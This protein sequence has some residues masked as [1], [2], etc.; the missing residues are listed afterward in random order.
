MAE[1][2]VSQKE[3]DFYEDDFLK[4]SGLVVEAK[5]PPSAEKDSLKKFNSPMSGF[6]VTPP[7]M[8][9]KEDPK[10]SENSSILEEDVPDEEEDY[11]DE[12][13]EQD[14]QKS[15][16]NKNFLGT[17]SQSGLPPLASGKFNSVTKIGNIQGSAVT[18]GDETKT[19]KTNPLPSDFNV[20]IADSQMSI[21]F[22]ISESKG[23]FQMPFGS[24]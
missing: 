22:D 9:V 5:V 11:K 23:T 16:T 2:I 12:E 3:E 18:N 4:S 20:N 17:L 6:K 13:F 10:Q 1:S 21:D 15:A 24:H 14:S 19:A 8:E 7:I